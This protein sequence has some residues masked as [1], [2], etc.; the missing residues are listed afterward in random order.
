MADAKDIEVIPEGI[1]H[2]TTGDDIPF[3]TQKYYAQR[4]SIFSK[5]DD[6]IWMTDDLWFGVTPEPVAM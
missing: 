3:E 1:H 6:G 4:H 2:Y 5:Y